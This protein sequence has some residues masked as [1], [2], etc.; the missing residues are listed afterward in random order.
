MRPSTVSVLLLPNLQFAW[1]A[2]VLLGVLVPSSP[3]VVYL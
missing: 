1:T 3:A 2:G